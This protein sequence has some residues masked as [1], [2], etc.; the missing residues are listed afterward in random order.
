MYLVQ[1]YTVR[2]NLIRIRPLYHIADIG[3]IGIKS[4]FNINMLNKV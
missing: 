4:T 2:P 3:T 1:F